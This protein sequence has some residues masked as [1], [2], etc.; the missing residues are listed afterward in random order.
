MEDERKKRKLAVKYIRVGPSFD[1]FRLKREVDILAS[2]NHPCIVGLFGWSLP[3]DSCRDARIGMEYMC[4]GS[5]ENVLAQVS[6]GK[7]PTFWTHENISVMIVGIILGMEYLHS[8]DIIHRDLKPGNILLDEKYRIRICDFGTARFEMCGTVTEKMVG[9][10]AYMAPETFRED[11]PTKKVDVFA[12][13]LIL[14]E[15]L[16]GK[17]VFP[18]NAAIARICGLHQEGFRPKIPESV[19]GL[20]ASVIEKCW[21]VNP[22]DRPSFGEIHKKLR[23]NWFPFFKD[24]IGSRMVE[25]FISTVSK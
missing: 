9:T 6:E 23:K 11:D 24:V 7:A 19:S 14:Y 8:K 20:V 13:G 15:M 3:N 22:D 12:F 4:N 1:S 5:L 10:A 18:K 16:F 21:S 25:D 2:L 17:S